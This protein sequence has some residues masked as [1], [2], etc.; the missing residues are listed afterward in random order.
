MIRLTSLLIFLIVCIQLTGQDSDTSFFNSAV[1]HLKNKDYSEA[2]DLAYKSLEINPNLGDAYIL[3]GHIYAS[4]AK[5]CYNDDYYIGIVYCL[6]VDMFEM[7]IKV[8]SSSAERAEGLIKTYSNYF[9]SRESI[10]FSAPL[11]GHRYNIGCWIN[12]ETT[13]RFQ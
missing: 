6:A 13:V 11:E 5:Q 8:D 9:P 7:A 12:R 1:R 10:P 3:I 4:S 2:R